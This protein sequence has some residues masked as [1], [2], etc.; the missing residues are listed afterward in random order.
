MNKSFAFLAGLAFFSATVVTGFYFGGK[1]WQGVVYLSGGTFSS[2]TRNPAAIKRDLDFSKLDGSELL[3]ATQKRLVSAAKVIATEGLLGVELGHFVARDTTGERRL[4]C[5]ALYD[6]VAMRFDAEGVASAG[7]IPEMEIDAPCK[8]SETDIASLTPVWIP[9]AKILGGKPVNS[10]LETDGVKFKF[11]S[12]NGSWPVSWRLKSV[13]LY[14]SRDT[15]REVSISNRE[16]R[17]IRPQAFVLN[18]LEARK[19]KN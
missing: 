6:R 1:S 19:Q 7:E 16:L 2:N 10:E 14:D 8:I 9:V 13:R 12:M 11:N 5:E 18:W 17:E 15:S 3:T 4:A